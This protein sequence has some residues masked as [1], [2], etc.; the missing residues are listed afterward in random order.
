MKTILSF[1]LLIVLLK[2]TIGQQVLFQSTYMDN[3]TIQ[4][5]NSENSVTNNIE[6]EGT[7][8]LKSKDSFIRLLLNSKENE[9]ILLFEAYYPLYDI[10]Q[11]IKITNLEELYL[12]KDV[13]AKNFE[14]QIHESEMNISSLQCSKEIILSS[15]KDETYR[16]EYQKEKIA[17]LNAKINS[18][19]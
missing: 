10:D 17:Q 6:I 9:K 1:C 16:I 5:V 3:D 7:I 14:I 2:C 19:L 8:L 12:I 18:V 4:I 15:I 13:L 11:I